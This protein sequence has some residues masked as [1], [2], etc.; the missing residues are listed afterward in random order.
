MFLDLCRFRSAL[1]ISIFSAAFVNL[2]Y[3]L[4]NFT[5]NTLNKQDERGRRRGTKDLL[6]KILAIISSLI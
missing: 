5:D 1:Y 2:N 4:S 3:F 6:W